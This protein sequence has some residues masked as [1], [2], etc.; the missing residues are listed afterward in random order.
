MVDDKEKWFHDVMDQVTAKIKDVSDIDV[1]TAVVDGVTPGR[2]ENSGDADNPMASLKNVTFNNITYYA[3]TTMQ[4]DG[5]RYEILPASRDDDTNNDMRDK[6]IDIHSNNTSSAVKNWNNMAHIAFT[7]IIIIAKMS[8]AT[9]DK[10][11]MD[12]VQR[13]RVIPV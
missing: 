9:I 3:R 7:A 11:T 5:D 1:I 8:G 4:L 12:L 6:V 2:G 13:F 10:D